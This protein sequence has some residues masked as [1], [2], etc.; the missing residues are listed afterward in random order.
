MLDFDHKELWRSVQG[1]RF[2]IRRGR[3]LGRSSGPFGTCNSAKKHHAL[4]SIEAGKN[5]VTCAPGRD[6]R[7]DGPRDSIIVIVVR[8]DRL[9][10]IRNEGI[11]LQEISP[12]IY[13]PAILPLR[14]SRSST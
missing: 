2:C 1:S 9:E 6:D 3:R 7:H 5:H 11:S 4:Q 13:A 12:A 10:A 8:L 14:P